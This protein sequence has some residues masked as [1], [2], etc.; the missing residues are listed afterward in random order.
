[1][2]PEAAQIIRENIW[3]TPAVIATHVRQRFPDIKTNQIYYVWKR[4]S[5]ALWKRDPDQL[6]SAR[7]LIQEKAED[8]DLFEMES[9]EGVVTLGW[10]LKCVATQMKDVVE[11]AL[12]ATC[13]EIL[14]ALFILL[15][16]V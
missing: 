2:S 7:K 3:A 13:K 4:M 5:Q 15:T 11:V 12:D 10:G 16:P 9:I 6:I 8:V 14:A 1:M